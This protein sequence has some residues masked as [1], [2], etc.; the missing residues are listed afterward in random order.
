MIDTR[1]INRTVADDL[2]ADTGCVRATEILSDPAV[3]IATPHGTH[4]GHRAES[5]LARK[6][7]LIEKPA[8]LTRG[9]VEEIR[10]AA[11]EHA[12]SRWRPCG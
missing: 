9:Q 12:S 5:H 4:Q 10:A 6:H 7:M 11:A 8:A 3:A 1:Q 2:P